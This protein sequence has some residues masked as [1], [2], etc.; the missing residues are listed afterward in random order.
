MTSLL[1]RC[2]KV[3][4]RY[5]LLFNVEPTVWG[6]LTTAEMSNVFGSSD[7]NLPTKVTRKTRWRTTADMASMTERVA[8]ESIRK[9]GYD[10]IS[11]LVCVA[12]PPIQ[13]YRHQIWLHLLHKLWRRQTWLRT[14][15]STHFWIRYRHY[16]MISTR[17]LSFAARITRH[18]ATSGWEPEEPGCLCITTP[19]QF[20]CFRLSGQSM[21]ICAI[22][23]KQ[24][25]CTH[26]H[27]TS[28]VRQARQ[29]EQ[30][31]APT[32]IEGK[33]LFETKFSQSDDEPKIFGLPKSP[34]G[35]PL[36]L[37]CSHS[38]S[39]LLVSVLLFPLCHWQF[40]LGAP[41]A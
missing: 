32:F 2:T 31:T 36:L 27:S 39:C 22:A 12:I 4:G 28:I 30:R 34:V 26:L 23:L 29:H 38:F 8:K 9:T 25:S 33:N 37:L 24:E 6:S 1:Y 3:N 11:I 21:L 15:L 20:C 5:A 13:W 40:I 17:N 19:R 18:K 41:R 16:K 35:T 7:E 10:T 14:W